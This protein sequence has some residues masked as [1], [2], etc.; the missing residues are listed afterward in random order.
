MLNSVL[1]RS[2]VAAVVIITALSGSVNRAQ[3]EVRLGI[4]PR[5]SAVELYD[6][7][8]PLAVYLSKETGE[9]VCLVIPRD[10][11]AFKAAV[12]AGQIDV[13]F[14]NPLIYVQLKKEL[15]LDP[16]AL[17]SE[18]KAGSQ[19]RGVIIARKD[20]TIHSLRDLKGKRL[21]F[22]EKS[23]AAGYLFQLMTLSSAGL[24]VKKD[25]ITLPFA[26]KHDVVVKAVF[27]GAADAGGLREDDLEKQKGVLDLSQLRIVA[28]TDYY[29]NWPLFAAPTLRKEFSEK[30]RQALL[31]LKPGSTPARQILG[32][33]R[34]TGFVPVS[35]QDYDGL[36]QAAMAA[37]AL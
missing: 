17:A 16:L 13:G 18:P 25:L 29:P 19:F 15:L 14:A 26:K 11:D 3:A 28:Y 4:L 21:M 37:G 5:L 33:G 36:R 10:F 32:P 12:R 31:K 27:N 1:I 34:L 20:S 7:F 24:D 35:D 2:I 22:V 8:N 30:L 23:S 9:K 6:M